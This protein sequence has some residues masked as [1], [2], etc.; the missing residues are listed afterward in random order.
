MIF[1]TSWGKRKCFGG[2]GVWLKEGDKNSRFFH[3]STMKHRDTN[4]ICEIKKG[5]NTIKEDNEIAEEAIM[6]FSFILT[7]DLNMEEEEKKSFLTPFP[8][9]L[10]MLRIRPW[11]LSKSL[12]KFTRQFFLY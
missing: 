11:W 6:Y 5:N 10:V 9:L 3:L 12:K 7:K 1:T 8:L 2:R 4:R